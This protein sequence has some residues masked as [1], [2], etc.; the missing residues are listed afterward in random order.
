MYIIELEV[1]FQENY[2]VRRIGS[3]DVR[4]DF[5]PKLDTKFCIQLRLRVKLDFEYT[6]YAISILFF[7]FKV[8][9]TANQTEK[10]LVIRIRDI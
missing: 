5:P 8:T 7:L 10:C 3:S 9:L 1:G 4:Q 6:L 2:D